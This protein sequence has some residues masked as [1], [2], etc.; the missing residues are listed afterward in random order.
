MFCLQ[1]FFGYTAQ[2]LDKLKYAFNWEDPLLTFGS[3]VLLLLHGFLFSLLLQLLSFLPFHYWR[4]FAFCC[5]LFGATNFTAAAK[6]VVSFELSKLEARRNERLAAAESPAA[7]GAAAAGATAFPSMQKPVGTEAH[8]DSANT[9]TG[10]RS[11]ACRS[12]YPQ[13]QGFWL[14]GILRQRRSSSSSSSNTTGTKTMDQA[15]AAVP[16][17]RAAG[18]AS[19]ASDLGHSSGGDIAGDE[20]LLFPAT[21]GSGSLGSR[22]RQLLLRGCMLVLAVC[23]SAFRVV[24]GLLDTYITG[25]IICAAESAV[26][27]Y[28]AIIAFWWLHLPE[29]R[30]MEHRQIAVSQ[31][32]P[33]LSVL[34]P[35][36]DREAAALRPQQQQ[37]QQH[38]T[39]AT[40]GAR[41]Q[42]AEEGMTPSAGVA[43][44]KPHGLYP[45]DVYTFLRRYC[46]SRWQRENP[47]TAQL[48]AAAPY[49]M[50]RSRSSSLGLD[51][52]PSQQ[53]QTKRETTSFSSLSAELSKA[54]SSSWGFTAGDAD[55][56]QAEQQ[57]QQQQAG[58]NSPH[59]LGRCGSA[60]TVEGGTGLEFSQPLDK[61]LS[62]SA[63]LTHLTAQGEID[64]LLCHPEFLAWQRCLFERGQQPAS[65]EMSEEDHQHL[66][67]LSMQRQ[68]QQQDSETARSGQPKRAQQQQQQQVTPDQQGTQQEAAGPFGG[69]GFPGLKAFFGRKSRGRLTASNSMP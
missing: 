11:S 22:L 8:S 45:R 23:L 14:A 69:L 37:H 66:Q 9:S 48:Y 33:S 68:P 57:Q 1:L 54:A 53:Q 52:S 60:G 55:L 65:D 36:E 20:V 3:V 62:A 63:S 42:P 40:P 6:S 56:Q 28:F 26:V 31:L 34:I 30:E 50:P 46:R 15:P 21:G 18:G 17:A 5:L 39:A 47:V 12:A 10:D 44:V 58:S 7:A 13:K 24:L 59:G 19:S 51:E 67:R 61:G 43:D 16:S 27:S 64:R 25:R 38:T 4:L 41:P 49:L 2:F 29:Q 32:L 35:P